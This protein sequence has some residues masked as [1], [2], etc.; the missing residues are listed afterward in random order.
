MSPSTSKRSRQGPMSVQEARLDAVLVV[1][2][3]PASNKPQ[4]VRIF[5]SGMARGALR[6]IRFNLSVS[7]ARLSWP[8]SLK[9]CL[10]RSANSR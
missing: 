7:S 4:S 6:R 9:R 2:T 3:L 8:I 10:I 1:F 5:G